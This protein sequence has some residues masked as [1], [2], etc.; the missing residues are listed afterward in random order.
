M[1]ECPVCKKKYSQVVEYCSECRVGVIRGF[2]E[3]PSKEKTFVEVYRTEDVALAGLIKEVLGDHK[4]ICYLDNYFI[5]HIYSP[6]FSPVKVMV[7]KED[8]DD[9]TEVINLFF[10]QD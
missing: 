3:S 4:V 9:A 10:R 5:A 2:N 6:Y 7:Y 8:V 1:N